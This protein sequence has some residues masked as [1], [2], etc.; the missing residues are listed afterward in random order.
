[1]SESSGP[2]DAASFFAAVKACDHQAVRACLKADP[3][4]VSATDE[5]SF[6]APAVILAAGRGD[7]GMI[8]LL[9]SCGA[10][11]DQRSGWWAGGFTALNSGHPRDLHRDGLAD[12]LI[13]RGATIDAHSAAG[14]G[15]LERLR[16]LVAADPAVVHEPGGDGLRPLHYA[17]SPEIAAFLLDRGAEIDARDVDHHGTAAQWNVLDRPQVSR[18]LV[19]RGAAA[20]LFLRVPLGDAAAVGAAVEADPAIL[21]ALSEHGSAPGGHVHEYTVAGRTGATP[22]MVACRWAEPEMVDLLL[23]LGARVEAAPRGVTALHYAAWGGRAENARRLV[24][25]GAP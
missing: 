24:D 20:D 3:A 23:A 13:D 1:M 18:F 11:I 22:L 15:R 4:L 16:E 5:S 12:F 7:R 25:A 9:L 8:D 10:D 2:H 17:A 6:D 14:L 21:E 19:E